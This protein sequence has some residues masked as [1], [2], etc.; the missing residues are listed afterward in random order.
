MRILVNAALLPDIYSFE[1]IS[2][3]YKT[4]YYV[5]SLQSESNFF[6]VCR[7]H[8]A[9]QLDKG[10]NIELIK[11][12]KRRGS[13]LIWK[14]WYDVRIP[15]LL[16]KYK[17]DLF[18]SPGPVCSLNTKVP[19][20]L[21][22]S[23]TSLLDIPTLFSKPQLS[24]LR[25]RQVLSVKKARSIIT[26]T[27]S[28]KNKIITSFKQAG[29][30]TVIVPFILPEDKIA[31]T[32]VLK[33]QTK[34]KH[35]GGKEF[36]L[37]SGPLNAVGNILNLLKAFS[38]F[39]KRQQSS[40]K[41]AICGNNADKHN[42]YLKLLETYKYKADVIL[43]NNLK[44]EEI[45]T[46]F[47]SAYSLVYPVLINDLLTPVIQAMQ[48]EI[49][50]ITSLTPELKEITGNAGLYADAENPQDIADN[51]MRIYKDERLRNELIE[52]GKSVINLLKQ[53]DA[54]SEFYKAMQKAVL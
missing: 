10:D 15:A 20:L 2:A 25:K 53:Q 7:S 9:D 23:G 34:A 4:I 19:Q 29:G 42:E 44:E 37:Y 17:V 39:K 8:D 5:A 49:P 35:T 11:T 33:E 54:V 1:Y 40:F 27:Q 28:E 13:P 43:K 51:M 50:V 36:F 48:Y 12:K 32:D 16:R 52:K 45:N 24:F 26:F 46:L 47:A 3:L 22:L 6:F 18:L 21:V 30:K 14:Y 31:A 38:L 41:L